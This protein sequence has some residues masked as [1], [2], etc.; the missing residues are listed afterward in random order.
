MDQAEIRMR[1]IEA[2]AKSPVPHRDGYSAGILEAAK[3][4]EQW[5][6]E[7]QGQKPLGLPK[8]GGRS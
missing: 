5:V 3:L 1:C 4:W 8:T 6:R 7:G 2:A